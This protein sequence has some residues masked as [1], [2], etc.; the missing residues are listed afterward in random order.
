MFGFKLGAVRHALTGESSFC[1]EGW[2][3]KVGMLFS[4]K[5]R[6]NSSSNNSA[7]E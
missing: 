7:L 6:P 2:V 1:V 3:G 5:V 4:M